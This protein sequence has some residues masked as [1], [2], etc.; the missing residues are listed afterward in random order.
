[1][2]RAAAVHRQG[3]AKALGERV[4]RLDGVLVVVVP[5]DVDAL[6]QDL[7]AQLLL[8]PGEWPAGA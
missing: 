2:Q 5:A 7:L 8:P 4:F 1:M 3:L 6:V